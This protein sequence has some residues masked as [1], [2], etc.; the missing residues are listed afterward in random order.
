VRLRG[1]GRAGG[2]AGARGATRMGATRMGATR[3]LCAKR[4]RNRAGGSERRARP[5]QQLGHG[6]VCLRAPGP[7]VRITAT[8]R[9][10]WLPAGRLERGSGR[11][12]QDREDPP[13]PRGCIRREG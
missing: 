13:P 4:K 12:S 11:G 7:R 9:P 2:D 5:A 1:R 8:P 3:D 6:K 10:G